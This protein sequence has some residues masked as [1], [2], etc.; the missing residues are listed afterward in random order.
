VNAPP[1]G[2]RQI[3]FRSSFA[4]KDEALEVVTLERESS[5]WRVVGYTIQ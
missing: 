4:G 5:G 2:Y 1:A 3:A